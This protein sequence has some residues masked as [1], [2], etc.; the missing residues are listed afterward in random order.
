MIFWTFIKKIVLVARSPLKDRES[1]GTKQAQVKFNTNGGCPIELISHSQSQPMMTSSNGKIFRVTDPLCGE[2]TGHRGALMF[3][4]NCTLN[5]RLCNQSRGWWF[6]TPPGP[7]W[8]H[9]NAC[10]LCGKSCW[11]PTSSNANGL[12]HTGDF[13]AIYNCSLY[14][15]DVIMSASG[16]QITGVSIVYSTVCLCRKKNFYQKLFWSKV[17]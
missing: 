8:R 11:T 12:P 16:S 13:N 7:L 5:K 14:Y 9:S 6:Q 1:L 2:F 3:S 10:R 4:L 17:Q 15:S